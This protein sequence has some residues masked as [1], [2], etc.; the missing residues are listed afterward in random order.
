MTSLAYVAVAVAVLGVTLL[1][2]LHA[3]MRHPASAP[4]PPEAL[5][6]FRLD[7][8]AVFATERLRRCTSLDG[9]DLRRLL[10]W[11]ATFVSAASRPMNGGGPR[12]GWLVPPNVFEVVAHL[13]RESD[14]QSVEVDDEC[15]WE[16]VNLH[17]EY[18]R[19]LDR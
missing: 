1:V 7:D 17:D 15:L 9:A 4:Y 19:S 18:L 13:R 3:R 8:A 5:H 11:C 12:D 16:V 10:D 6:R 2:I 14:A